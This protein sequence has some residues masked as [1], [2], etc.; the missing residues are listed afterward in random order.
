VVPGSGQTLAAL[1]ADAIG[2]QL[3]EEVRL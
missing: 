3:N 2:Q 1:M